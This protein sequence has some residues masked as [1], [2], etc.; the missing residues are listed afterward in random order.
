MSLFGAAQN[1]INEYTKEI[2]RK[3]W[4]SYLFSAKLRDLRRRKHLSQNEVA[5][6]TNISHS[7]IRNYEQRK[8][9]PTEQ[10]LNE[11]AMA[12]DIRPEALHVYDISVAPA[13]A[14][15]QLGEIYGLV[16][17]S[18]SQYAALKPVSAFM[19]R[20]I[21]AWEAQ[22]RNLKHGAIN[23]DQYENWKDCYSD[24]YEYA[25][26]AK[27]CTGTSGQYQLLEPWEL[28]NLS[29]TLRRLRREKQMTQ[30]D[31]SFVTG[32]PKTTIRSYEQKKHS[33]KI[34][35]I[36]LLAEALSIS[37]GT[38][39]FFDFGSPIQ[40]A[41]ALFQIANTYALIPDVL[42]SGEPVLRTVRPGLEQIIDQWADELAAVNT[43]T[44]ELN[45]QSWKDIY[46]PE[47]DY[48]HGDFRNS[49]AGRS[50]YE[51]VT[52][53]KGE[54]KDGSMVIGTDRCS[55]YDPY[56]YRYKN[57]FLRA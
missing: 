36:P 1:V 53:D 44:A 39:T 33:P 51:Y 47:A 31:L 3:Q 14:L 41:H 48:E 40:A 6:R 20:T 28:I 57:G 23:R 19:T 18:N 4:Q 15:F 32:I 37:T 13:H 35:Q 38:L 46:N 42:E 55:K 2:A 26:F 10:H 24:D 49:Y 22:Y 56:D 16:P 12:F 50:R 29:D 25:D 43:G 21:R 8:S 5:S 52:I 7:A 34:S 11:I 45:Y 27:R 30:Q 54:G 17:M 9:H